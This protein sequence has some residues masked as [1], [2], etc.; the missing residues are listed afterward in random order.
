MDS[1]TTDMH[2]TVASNVRAI[3]T[4]LPASPTQLFEW[5]VLG[6]GTLY[7]AQIPIGPD[8]AVVTGGIDE[9]ARQ[10]F[11][12]L[13]QTLSAAG[14]SHRDV[15]QILIYVTDRTWLPAVNAVY[16]G[17][18]SAPFPNRASI[19]VAGLAREEMLIEIVA[20]ACPPLEKARRIGDARAI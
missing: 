7:T 14:A 15:A 12:N 17:H 19:V 8:G 2:S 4:G 13:R 10:V 6:N 1:D 18:F 20:Y 5:A 16:R 9:Q 3:E 11:E